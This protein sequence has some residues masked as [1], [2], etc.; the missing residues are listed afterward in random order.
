MAVPPG[1][2]TTD[3]SAW[4]SPHLLVMSR[5]AARLAPAADRDDVLQEALTIAW[6]RQETFDSARGT[7]AAWLCTIVANAARRRKRPRTESLTAEMPEKASKQ[8]D[9]GLEMDV[10]RAL[11]RLSARQLQAVDLHY[12][13][14]LSVTETA[15]VMGCSAGTVKSTLYDAPARLRQ[16]LGELL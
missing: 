9:S 13:A 3:F 5:V 6:R 10:A 2:V 12:Y 7:P 1:N 8:A 15:A 14:G 16:M 11:S 4:V